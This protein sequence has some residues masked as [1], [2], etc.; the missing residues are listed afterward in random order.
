MAALLLG[1][2][3]QRA[4]NRLRFLLVIPAKA[5]ILLFFSSYFFIRYSFLS[6]E[7]DFKYSRS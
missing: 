3:Q 6:W 1:S 2:L 5:G 7:A 4:Q